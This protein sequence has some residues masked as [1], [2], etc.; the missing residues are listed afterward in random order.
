[1]EAQQILTV[2][3]GPSVEGACRGCISVYGLQ[4]LSSWLGVGFYKDVLKFEAQHWV[5]SGSFL[6]LIAVVFFFLFIF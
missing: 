2:A 3:R 5:E 6:F 4:N 1:M